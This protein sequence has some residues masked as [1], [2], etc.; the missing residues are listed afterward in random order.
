MAGLSDYEALALLNFEAGREPMPALAARYFALFTTAPTSN[1]GTGGTEVSGNGYARVQVAG[2][3]TAGAAWTTSS[4]TI[5]LAATAPAWLTALGTAGSGVNVYDATSGAQIGTVSAVSGTTVTLTADALAASS[6]AS[7]SLVFSAFGAPTASSGTEP[8]VTPANIASA[9]AIAYAQATGSGWSTVVAWGLYDALTSGNYLRGD[10]LG[11][12]PWQPCTISAASPGIFTVDTNYAAGATVVFSA[13]DG[14]AV[15]TFSQSN[16][17][18]PLL[19]VS[20]S[21]N[22]FSVTNSGTAVNTSSVGS[23][24]VRQVASQDIAGNVTYSLPAGE[25]VLVVA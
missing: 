13:K 19:V 18:G 22:N 10:W 24:M 12:Y 6:G 8:A 21:G 14:G 16:L 23:G 25:A 5:T 7:D 9:A 17:D 20:P 2:A 15:P 4:S 1:A 3:L 11:N